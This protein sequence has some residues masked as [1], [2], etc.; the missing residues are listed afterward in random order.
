MKIQ[1]HLLVVFVALPS[2]LLSGCGGG[3]SPE[4]AIRNA[5]ETNIQRLTNLYVRH[6]MLNSWVGPANEGDFKSFIEKVDSVTLSSIGVD[7]GSIDGLFV[8]ER[9]SQPFKIVYGVTGSSRG[10]NDAVIFES[11]GVDGVRQVGFTSMAIREYSGQ[12]DIDK[13][14]AGESVDSNS[15]RSDNLPQGAGR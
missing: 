5:N 2:L 10:S 12:A 1:L 9:D 15:N 8:S 11:T 4:E 7:L 6:Q 13:L 14:K 3:P